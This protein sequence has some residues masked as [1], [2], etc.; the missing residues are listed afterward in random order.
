LFHFAFRGRQDHSAI[1]KVVVSAACI[2][3][4]TAFGIRHLVALSGDQTM[5]TATTHSDSLLFASAF[6]LCVV[7]AI[8][9]RDKKRLKVCALVLPILTL[10]MIANNRRLVWVQVAEAMITVY[11]IMPMS[12]FKRK[13]IRRLLYIVPAFA[14]YLIVG[15][16][17][18]GRIFSAAHTIRSLFDSKSDG[19]T[20][21][22]DWEN[23]DL[24]TTFQSSPVFGLGFGHPFLQPHPV[25]IEITGYE[26]EPFQ[27]HNSLLGL[28]AFGGVVGF[29]LLWMI[30][31]VGSFFAVRCY[32]RATVP[33]DRAA[34]LAA[35]GVFVA[36][37]AL[38]Y[39]DVGYGC[40]E[41]V[42]FGSLALCVVGKLALI[43][44]AWPSRLGRHRT[45][46]VD[47]TPR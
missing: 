16:D 43:T 36:N 21:W 12:R 6:C 34:A 26:L 46:V 11:L 33:A 2:R 23:F 10:G 37:L 41:S 15:W 32:R 19:S 13:V 35:L 5:P 17:S 29:T 42:F 39:G 47:G 4:A 18:N 7:L 27:P 1:A 38:C 14:A 9:L 31:T 30:F 3:A 45:V 24:V 40:W 22:R 44:D 25:A 28:W 20:E 8:E